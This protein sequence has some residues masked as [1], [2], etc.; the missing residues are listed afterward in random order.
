M[1]FRRANEKLLVAVVDLVSGVGDARSRVAQAYVQLR[2]L[3][4]TELPATKVGEWRSILQALTKDGPERDTDGTLWAPAVE[5]TTRRMR[6]RT[7]SKIAHRIFTLYRDLQ[8]KTT[9][10]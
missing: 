8:A 1:T 2:R 7:A 4:D 6:N 9:S 10:R 3:T 5:N